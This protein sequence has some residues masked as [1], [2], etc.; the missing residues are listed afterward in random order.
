VHLQYLGV[1]ACSLNQIPSTVGNLRNLQT[2][3]VRDTFV[4]KL[5]GAFWKIRTLRHVFG[6]GITL[7][8]RVGDLKHLQT[9]ETILAD[10]KDGWDSRTFT[11]MVHLQSL[12]LGDFSNNTENAKSLSEAIK[13]S[14]FL[15]Y[16]ETLTIIYE[17]NTIPL[18]VFTSTSQRRIRALTLDGK[19][20]LTELSGSKF[21]V[22]NLTSLSL[23]NTEVSQDFINK[24]GKL[25]LL[26]ELTLDENSYKDNTLVFSGGASRFKSLAHLML[27]DLEN[28]N[29]FEICE[30]ALPTLS[31]LEILSCPEV[32]IKICGKSRLREKIK[33]EDVEL[34][35][36]ITNVKTDSEGQ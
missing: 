27:W 15:E 28:L 7:T 13:K 32:D 20:D 11:R 14:D 19:L 30:S 26:L 23:E 6:S 18:C 4:Q 8:K 29:K 1:T 31:D 17:T 22:P 2:L 25:P 35:G 36:R 12:R 24:L 10:E 5:P 34:Y 16:L 3:D 33:S 9:L 21:C